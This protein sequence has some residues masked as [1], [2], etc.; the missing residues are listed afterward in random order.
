MKMIVFLLATFA[1]VQSTDVTGETRDDVIGKERDLLIIQSE[2]HFQ[3]ID[4]YG[5]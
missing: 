3:S 1:V 4:Q 2:T 5:I